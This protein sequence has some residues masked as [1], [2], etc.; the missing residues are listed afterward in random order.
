MVLC[1]HVRGTYTGAAAGSQLSELG[2]L[3]NALG[4]A[5]AGHTFVHPEPLI[6]LVA[7]MAG[8]T[9]AHEAQESVLN[10]D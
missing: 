5:V 2:G 6:C 3:R 1:R 7:L 8:T 10:L 4:F 9:L